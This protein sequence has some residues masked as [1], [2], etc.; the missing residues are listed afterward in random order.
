MDHLFEVGDKVEWCG[1]PGKVIYIEGDDL[2]V[3]FNPPNMGL[4]YVQDHWF[5]LDGRF[6]PWHKEKSLRLLIEK[7]EQGQ[8]LEKSKFCSRCKF[9]LGERCGHPSNVVIKDTAISQVTLYKQTPN[10]KNINN[11]CPFYKE[12]TLSSILIRLGGILAIALCLIFLYKI[13]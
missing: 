12:H 4:G 9:Y 10:Q 2:Q 13:I 3:R 5:V 7:K 1:V 11:L 6:L 8:P